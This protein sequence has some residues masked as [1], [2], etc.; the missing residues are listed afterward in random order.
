[1]HCSNC[2][3][4]IEDATKFCQSCGKQ[5]GAQGNSVAIEYYAI[6]PK[7]LVLFSI[8]TFGI[9]EIYWFY[10]NWQ[11]VKKFEGQKISPFWRAIFA[12]FFCYSLFK[13]VQESAKS[14]AY[15]NLYSPGWLATAYIFLLLVGNGLSKVDSYEIGFNL[16]W[17]IVA[18]STF[19]PL[20][21]VQKAI[22]FNNE[23]VKGSLELKRDFSGG[24]VALIVIGVLWFL[25]VLWGTFLP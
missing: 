24:E 4:K 6:S 8:L 1:M 9:Y 22:N 14:H 3:T 2:G 18:V 21:P 19:I 20:L 11:A 7:R 23:K 17:L 13:K 25:L 16:I 10:K 5:V 12:V 15:Q